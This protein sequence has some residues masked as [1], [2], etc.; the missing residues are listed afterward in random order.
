MIEK[1]NMGIEVCLKR[2]IDCV[3]LGQGEMNYLKEDVTTIL[4]RQIGKKPLWDEGVS[5]NFSDTL[6]I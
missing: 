2:F 4:T 3:I 1:E 5:H 6:H